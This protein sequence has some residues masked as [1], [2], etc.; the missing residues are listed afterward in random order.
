MKNKSILII[1]AHP[2]F[3]RSFIHKKCMHI[4]H[5]YADNTIVDLYEDYPTF[6]ID[7]KEQQNLLL[8]HDIIIFHYPWRWFS[9]PALLQEWKETVLTNEFIIEHDSLKD[10]IFSSVI[11]VEDEQEDYTENG[12]YHMN[13]NALLSPQS[14]MAEICQMVYIPPL[15]VYGHRKLLNAETKS[16]AI[17]ALKPYFDIY[18]TFL[19]SLKN[20]NINIPALQKSSTINDVLFDNLKITLKKEISIEKLTQVTNDDLPLNIQ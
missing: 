3:Q 2:T 19:H 6:I 17:E 1:L 9:P 14:K 12:M 7:A 8:Q 13:I 5:E 15:I 20:D 11:S 18:K 4:A 10:K 16:Q